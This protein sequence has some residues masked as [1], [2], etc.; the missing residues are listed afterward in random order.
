M[1]TED[2]VVPRSKISELSKGIEKLGEKYG[3]IT[4]IMGHIGD[5]NIHPN[6]ALDLRDSDTRL[7][8][9][10]LKK[11]LFELAVSLGE[12]SQAN[13]VSAVKKPVT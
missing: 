9:E 13:T 4:L 1:I 2:V 10:K 8:F 7:R 5:G 3:I 12:H 11:E 6:F